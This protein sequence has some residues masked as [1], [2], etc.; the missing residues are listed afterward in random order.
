[1]PHI[2]D[3]ERRAQRRR[4][5]AA[6][7]AML[8]KQAWDGCCE[9]VGLHMEERG[10]GYCVVRFALFPRC[11]DNTFT[12][13]RAAGDTF[14]EAFKRVCAKLPAAIAEVTADAAFRAECADEPSPEQRR[15]DMLAAHAED[16]ADEAWLEARAAS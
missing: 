3:T 4:D 8:Q 6:Q 10:D 16:R 5:Y 14:P 1:M 11:D 15:A 13:V 9:V 7:I 2:T 12:N